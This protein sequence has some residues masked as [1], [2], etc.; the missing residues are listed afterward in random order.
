MTKRKKNVKRTKRKISF[1]QK[2][3]KIISFFILL[4]IAIP[5]VYLGYNK[6]TNNHKITQNNKYIDK[7]ILKKMNEMLQNEKR[8]VDI[9]REELKNIKTQAKNSNNQDKY[10]SESIDYK[11]SLNSKKSISSPIKKHKITLHSKKPF[12]AIIMDDVSFQYEV[13]SIKKI[14]FK[15]TP[16]IFP[17]TKRHP[18]TPNLAKEFKFYMVHLPLEAYN[19]PNPEPKTLLVTSSLKDIQKRIANIKKWFPKDKFINNHTGSKFTSNYEAMMRLFTVLKQNNMIFV[20][21]RTTAKTVA[22]E[23]AR[24][25][26]EKLLS[27]NVFLDNKANIFYIKEQLKKAVKLAKENGYAI[28]ICHPHKETFEALI[29]SKGILKSVKLVYIKEI[30]ENSTYSTK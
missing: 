20:D 14:P 2:Y 21:S 1:F 23:V 28:A 6:I 5:I 22:P 15:I 9:L 13:N 17:P 7:K 29:D 4:F 18:N 19:Y 10:S 24:S 3:K 12:L 25:F 16:S 8:K 26:R 11:K 27:R 30:Y